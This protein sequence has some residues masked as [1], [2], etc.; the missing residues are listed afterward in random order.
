MYC[1]HGFLEFLRK[2]WKKANALG[3]S[4][5]LLL[6]SYGCAVE[7]DKH[8]LNIGYLYSIRGR[9]TVGV[10]AGDFLGNVNQ[11]PFAFRIRDPNSKQVVMQG[12]LF[13]NIT[14]EYVIVGVPGGIWDVSI[15]GSTTLR[16]TSYRVAIFNDVKGLS[17][18]LK[19]GD[20]NGDN[21]INANDSNFVIAHNGALPANPYDG[22]DDDQADLDKS[23]EVDAAD[24]DVV[25]NNLGSGD[26]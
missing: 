11:M 14:G 12:T 10:N 17:Y 4:L 21:I 8:V 24:I 25:N 1:Y 20:A 18:I 15:K 13:T 3:L 16:K 26:P 6:F 2:F 23:G 5:V 9:I 22:S 7:V 19:N